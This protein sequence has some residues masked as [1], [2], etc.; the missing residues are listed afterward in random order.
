MATLEKIQKTVHIPYSLKHYF[1]SFS[2]EFKRFE[3]SEKLD[4][5]R[6][7]VRKGF[8]T[9][10]LSEAFR[11]PRKD[12]YSHDDMQKELVRYIAYELYRDS[13]D[14]IVSKYYEGMSDKEVA[15]D[16]DAFLLSEYAFDDFKVMVKEK[17]GLEIG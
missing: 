1:S 8:S 5:L 14:I 11:K 2:D 10:D 12:R 3:Y 6:T 17:F 16:L 13:G 4:F 7:V 15:K 9:Y